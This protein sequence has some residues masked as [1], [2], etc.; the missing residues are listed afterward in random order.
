ML[1]ARV[2][3]CRS[4]SGPAIV[5]R[6]AS[7][8][9]KA[10]CPMYSREVRHARRVETRE[11]PLFS[12][13]LFAWAED[14]EF[15]RLMSVRDTVDVLR[16]VGDSRS[17]GAVS[18]EVIVAL[19][20]DAPALDYKVGDGVEITHGRWEGYRGVYAREENERVYLLFKMLGREFEMPFHRTQTRAM[21]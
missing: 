10:I 12:C 3:V 11:Y 9:V 8:G 16:R 15:R 5:S 2:V 7:V 13:Y 1:S 18:A 21:R 14:D 19:S 20:C 4:L 6:Y 17:M